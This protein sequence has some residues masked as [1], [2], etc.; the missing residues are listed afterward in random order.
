MDFGFS[1]LL[2]DHQ[3]LEREARICRLLK[4]PNIGK[5]ACIESFLGVLQQQGRTKIHCFCVWDSFCP[6]V[7][8]WCPFWPKRESSCVWLRILGHSFQFR[9]QGVS[10]PVVLSQ[11]WDMR[12]WDRFQTPFLPLS[13]C[14]W[15]GVQAPQR[16][17]FWACSL[18]S[19][20]T[21]GPPRPS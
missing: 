14:L 4:H 6:W 18:P 12:Y 9:D 2:L 16:V 10:I 20:L 7:F 21:R 1:P 11:G 8:A 13:F 3:K 17:R 5:C 19:S 15:A